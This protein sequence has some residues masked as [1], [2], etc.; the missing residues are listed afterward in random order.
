MRL[1]RLAALLPLAFPLAP[2]AADPSDGPW[3]AVGYIEYA[4]HGP[5]EKGRALTTDG[6]GRYGADVDSRIEIKVDTRKLETALRARLPADPATEARAGALK[7]RLASLSDAARGIKEALAGLQ[8]LAEIC[9]APNCGDP[10]TFRAALRRSAGQRLRIFDALQNAQMQRLTDM[11]ASSEEAKKLSDRAME[12]ALLSPAAAKNLGYDWEALD[13][14]FRQEINFTEQALAAAA[15][16]LGTV[17]QIRA[18]LLRAGATP[19]A[20]PLPGYND[21]ETGTEHPFERL[22]FYLSDNEKALYDQYQQMAKDTK[23]TRDAAQA[24]LASLRQEFDQLREQLSALTA[25]LRTAFTSAEERLQALAGWSD[26]EKRKAWLTATKAELRRSAEGK[27]VAADLEAVE[28]DMTALKDDIAALKRYADLRTRLAGATAPDVMEVITSIPRLAEASDL[29][30]NPALRVLRGETWA[31]RTTHARALL[32]SIDKLTGAARERLVREGPVAELRAAVDAFENLNEA[33]KQTPARLRHWI[34]DVLVLKAGA[35]TAAALP[36][37]RGQKSLAIRP[38]AELS[39]EVNLLT[40]PAPLQERDT[41]RIEY[42]FLREEKPIAAGWR[43]DFVLSAYGW[44]SDVLASLAFAKHSGAATWKPSPAVSW[45]VSYRDWPKAGE[46]GAG[47][48]NQIRW[49]S[50]A[51]ISALTLN[52]VE[53]QDVEVGLAATLSF[54]NDRILAGYGA[55]LQ[56]DRNRTFVFI[57]LRLFSFTGS[58]AQAPGAR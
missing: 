42:R 22:R 19:L 55:N 6:H 56:A 20:L 35:N 15:P 37:P 39:T 14:L 26:T 29:D 25:E 57:S 49:F 50:G 53:G 1:A 52:Q 24:I 51:G 38:G 5:Y 16:D 8:L 18:H 46:R 13:A 11:G 12:T 40:T 2:F 44:R 9:K 27:T 47:A 31:Q 32:S 54:F 7:G 36:E 33:V 48:P 41:V 34:A 21:E 23:E 10:A 28:K 30:A 17:I 45:I 43:D 4:T 3:N 58:Q